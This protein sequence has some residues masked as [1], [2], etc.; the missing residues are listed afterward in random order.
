MYDFYESIFVF[1]F[2]NR[3]FLC[4]WHIACFSIRVVNL[5]DDCKIYLEDYDLRQRK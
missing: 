2:L 5:V 4:M 3:L 1:Q